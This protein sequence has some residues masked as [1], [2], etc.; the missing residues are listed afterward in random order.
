MILM[1]IMLWFSIKGVKKVYQMVSFFLLSSK[2][3]CHNINHI[4][5][6]WG[7]QV[8]HKRDHQVISEPEKVDTEKGIKYMCPFC[9]IA[10]DK[11]NQHKCKKLTRKNA[12]QQQE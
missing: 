11:L 9:D 10:F 1:C 8:Y 4:A 2:Q 6:N 3:T 7:N 12:K 5:N